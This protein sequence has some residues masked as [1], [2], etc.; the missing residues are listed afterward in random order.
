MEILPLEHVWLCV[1]YSWLCSQDDIYP[2]TH[3]KRCFLQMSLTIPSVVD[4]FI[5]QI[6]SN[7]LNTIDECPPSNQRHNVFSVLSEAKY[8]INLKQRK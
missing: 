7:G 2:A 5:D 3:P 1:M 6:W 8:D 4:P